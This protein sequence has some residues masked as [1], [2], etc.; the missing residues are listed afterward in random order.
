MT[1]DPENSI[2]TRPLVRLLPWAMALGFGLVAI[3]FGVR[4]MSLR[5][6]NEALQTQRELADLAHRLAQSQLAERTLVA[7]RVIA[8]LGA[9]LQ[10]QENP[11]RLTVV[12][13]GA[14]STD[15]SAAQAIILWDA[16]QHTGLLAAEK[17]PAL[18]GDEHYLL[19]VGAGA[20]F[21]AVNG[22][23]FRPDAEGRA[24]LTFKIERPAA[25]PMRFGISREKSDGAA[26][27]PG[28]LV[29]VSP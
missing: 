6:E 3:L 2:N 16:G 19:Q 15:S 27:S 9:N 7:E 10:R 18:A 13:L 25:A 14:P 11:D 23:L 26:N 4:L 17:L 28:A 22:G 5:A 1:N 29:L 12:T 24:K 20:D 21:S 8:E